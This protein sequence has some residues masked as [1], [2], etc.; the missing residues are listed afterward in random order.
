[1]WRDS[2]T[3]LQLPAHTDRTLVIASLE[4]DRK[5]TCQILEAAN[6]LCES[7]ADLSNLDDAIEHGVSALIIGSEMLTTDILKSL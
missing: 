2:L 4:K 1:M 3:P 6:I 5:L 7:I